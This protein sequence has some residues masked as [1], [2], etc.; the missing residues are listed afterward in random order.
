MTDNSVIVRGDA[1]TKEGESR[2]QMKPGHLAGLDA[3]GLLEPGGT[4]QPRFIK[5]SPPRYEF[6]ANIE[7]GSIE[8]YL[9]RRGDEVRARVEQNSG[10]E[11]TYDEHAPLYDAG[12]GTLDPEGSGDVVAYLIGDDVTLADGATEILEVEVA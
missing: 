1:L 9:C 11:V 7:A 8:F 10:V 2:V 3:D 4:N 6:D 5:E 12:D